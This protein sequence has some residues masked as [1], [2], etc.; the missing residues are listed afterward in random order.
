MN[1][2]IKYVYGLFDDSKKQLVYVG[3]TASPEKRFIQH[4]YTTA[5]DFKNTCRMEILESD[6][7]ATFVNERFWISYY[8]FLGCDLL[9]KD[10][11]TK[12]IPLER[13]KRKRVNSL[14]TYKRGK[15]FCSQ[16]IA[17]YIK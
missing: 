9:N 16:Y 13:G 4:R 3:L 8:R 12:R 7:E 10:D 11:G 17:G 2:A 14:L 1:P 15:P 6:S 5:K